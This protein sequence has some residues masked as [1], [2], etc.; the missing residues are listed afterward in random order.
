[1]KLFKKKYDHKKVN[2]VKDIVLYTSYAFE[3]KTYDEAIELLKNNN[4][5]KAIELMYER[6]VEAQ[7]QEYEMKLQIEKASS[8]VNSLATKSD[9]A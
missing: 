4:K 8:D 3:A 6:L 9:N 1:M 5:Q 7:K 2:R